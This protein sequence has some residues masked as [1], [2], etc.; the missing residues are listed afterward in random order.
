M[1]DGCFED[2]PD[3]EPLWAS[4]MKDFDKEELE[5]LI[6]YLDS[7]IAWFSQIGIA[8]S[9]SEDVLGF[10][11]G[12]PVAVN[13]SQLENAVLYAGNGD[14]DQLI[15]SISIDAIKITSKVNHN[16]L[17][18]NQC[19][20]FKSAFQHE[21]YDKYFYNGVENLS[22]F[23]YLDAYRMNLSAIS[24]LPV[25]YPASTLG[26]TPL[27]SF[28]YGAVTYISQNTSLYL[29]AVEIGAVDAVEKRGSITYYS[30]HGFYNLMLGIRTTAISTIANIATPYQEDVHEMMVYLG[31]D[32]AFRNIQFGGDY[33]DLR[34]ALRIPASRSN[35]LTLEGLLSQHESFSSIF[36]ESWF[37]HT[38]RDIEDNEKNED[39]TD[40]YS[41]SKG[42]YPELDNSSTGFYGS[43]N[44]GS[45]RYWY[46][47]EAWLN[48]ITIE[49]LSIVFWMGLDI[50]T[51]QGD[52]C[53][54]D[55]L[56]AIIIVIVIT[57][58]SAGLGTGTALTVMQ[59]LSVLS[60]ILSI[61]SITGIIT[62]KDAMIIGAVLAI[63]TL[64]ASLVSSATMSA[65]GMM[66]ASMRIASTVL[67]TLSTLDTLDV[68][69][70]ATEL[71]AITKELEEMT[72]DAEMWE[73]NFRFSYGG[74]FEMGVREGPEANP[75]M[76]VKDLYK[77]FEIY[78]TPGFMT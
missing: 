71:E 42:E 60:G 48:S 46:I 44:G 36:A 3:L 17:A 1:A 39:L 64:G 56:L 50:I 59:G 11:I 12:K 19:Y 61:A 74:S 16:G 68:M 69:R 47:S 49:Q 14:S 38:D 27:P 4:A 24:P 9:D 20:T 52:P 72:E 70:K 34:L 13:N 58:F 15:S 2:N 45:Y 66:M 10:S 55:E 78:K 77:E 32:E 43:K 54:F 63:A 35:Q 29:E 33:T 73:S 62:P 5:T 7:S 51:E 76:Y 31:V 28:V 8:G 21:F 6:A 57:Y 40:L 30:T 25:S 23:A 41:T 75:Y 53:P 18:A 67:D 26:T 37:T 65:Q 22:G